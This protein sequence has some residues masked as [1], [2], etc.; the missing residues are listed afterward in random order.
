MT[1]TTYLKIIITLPR[2]LNWTA[3]KNRICTGET[4]RGDS[5]KFHVHE[6]FTDG[7]IQAAA[8]LEQEL[9]KRKPVSLN[10]LLATPGFKPD[11]KQSDLL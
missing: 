2:R 6:V 5:K 4:K 1:C 11:R 10:M 3:L 7:E 9:K 8:P